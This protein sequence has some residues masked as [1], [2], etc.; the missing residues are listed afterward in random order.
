MAAQ[1]PGNFDDL[2]RDPISM[3]DSGIVSFAVALVLGFLAGLGVGGGSLLIMWLTL[4]LGMEHPQARII[5]LLFFI[6]AALI[7]SFFRWKQGSLN[8]KPVL[9]SVIAG[10]ISAGVFSMIS[11][12]L[13]TGIVQTI[14]GIIL[15]LAGIRELWY[16][17]TK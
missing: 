16:K 17:P 3:L 15:L 7:S 4:V 10:C 12:H 8:L 11:R 6:P 1:R 13:D 2:G 14:F 9:P 5:N